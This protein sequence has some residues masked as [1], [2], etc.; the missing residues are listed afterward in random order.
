MKKL[1]LAHVMGRDSVSSCGSENGV[2][3]SKLTVIVEFGNPNSWFPYV[4]HASM[5]I[6][7]HFIDYGPTVGTKPNLGIV[8][9]GGNYYNSTGYKKE[10]PETSE[11]N[12]ESVSNVIR[13]IDKFSTG[14]VVAAHICIC[15]TRAAQIEERM[16]E[17]SDGGVY[18]IPGQQCASTVYAAIFDSSPWFKAALSPQG[19]MLKYISRL[20]HECGPNKG[21]LAY[22]DFVKYRLT[23]ETKNK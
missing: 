13:N 7:D 16:R 23:P 18:S 12:T 14:Y 17:L 4:G 9:G 21:K 1:I 2:K 20:K 10:H 8:D 5:G 22:L 19:L 11:V 6:N 3:C 15:Q